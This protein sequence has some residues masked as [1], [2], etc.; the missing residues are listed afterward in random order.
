MHQKT[1]VG[2][3]RGKTAL[4]TVLIK[5][6]SFNR[7]SED[8]NLIISELSIEQAEKSVTATVCRHAAVT[9]AVTG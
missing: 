9:F 4:I 8:R 5:V 7:E 1:K 3:V 2:I 6:T